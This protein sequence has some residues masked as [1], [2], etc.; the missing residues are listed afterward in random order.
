MWFVGMRHQDISCIW[1]YNRYNLYGHLLVAMM[2]WMCDN[3]EGAVVPMLLKYSMQF[4]F[5]KSQL[6]IYA[7]AS[8]LGSSTLCL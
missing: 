7:A 1:Q 6:V 8:P 3:M 5:Q 4:K 2:H